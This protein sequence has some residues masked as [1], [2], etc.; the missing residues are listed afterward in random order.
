[1]MEFRGEYLYLFGRHFP[2][3]KNLIEKE[4]PSETSVRIYA[5]QGRGNNVLS[6]GNFKCLEGIFVSKLPLAILSP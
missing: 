2:I 4:N 3:D 6:T 1:M 5:T